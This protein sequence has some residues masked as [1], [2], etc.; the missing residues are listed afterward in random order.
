MIWHKKSYFSRQLSGPLCLWQMFRK[1]LGWGCWHVGGKRH[2]PDSLPGSQPNIKKEEKHETKENLQEG[3]TAHAYFFSWP[4]LLILPGSQP[5]IQRRETNTKQKRISK[6]KHMHMH[7]SLPYSYS[8][9][10][11]HNLIYKEGRQTRNNKKGLN[12]IKKETYTFSFLGSA[13]LSPPQ[14]K[15]KKKARKQFLKFVLAAGL[16]LRVKFTGTKLKALH[17]LFS[18]QMVKE[19]NRPK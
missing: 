1:S 19:G 16:C 14:K 18:S 10:V 12:N 11:G 4:C 6:K 5:N 2:F 15:L 8:Y 3:T 7:V 13:Q 17:R 9:Y